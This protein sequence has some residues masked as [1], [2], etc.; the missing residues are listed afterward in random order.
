MRH[1]TPAGPALV[2][3]VGPSGSGKTT[4]A[5]ELLRHW[6]A[7]GLRVGYVKHASHGFELD[8]PGKDSARAAAAGAD[9][10][11]LAGP[12]GTAF[13]E[14]VEDAEPRRLV[15]RFL[16]DRQLVVLEGFRAA[17]LPSVV[18][19][20]PAGREA[21]EALVRGPRLAYVLGVGASPSAAWDAPAPVFDLAAGEALAEHLRARLSPPARAQAREP[22]AARRGRRGRAEAPGRAEDPAPRCGPSRSPS[23]ADGRPEAATPA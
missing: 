5:V 20:G 15:E 3:L 11:V 16:A 13:L 1:P 12:Q 14:P 4:L 9:G 2:S 10:V 17:A 23:V 8:R 22:A 19:V 7:Q 18:V 6:R 21:S